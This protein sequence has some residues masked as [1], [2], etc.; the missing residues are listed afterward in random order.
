M[1]FNVFRRLHS[2]TVKVSSQILITENDVWENR[3]N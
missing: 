1:L 2:S 3:E